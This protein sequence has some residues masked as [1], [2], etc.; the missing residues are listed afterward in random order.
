[1][2]T[3]ASFMEYVSE[4][5]TLGGRLTYR[6]MF[7][8]YALYLDGVVVAFACD[9]QVFLKPTPAGEALAPSAAMLPAYPGSKLY[10]RLADELDDSERFARLLIA[11]AAA[12][13]PPK[14]KGK[15]K[16]SAKAKG[17]TETKAKAKPKAKTKTTAARTRTSAG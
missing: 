1:M 12:L 4:Q 7:G 5:A 9:N 6:K 13:P 10:L 2:A 17:T 3:D 15:A 8:E 14:S 11:T 16:S